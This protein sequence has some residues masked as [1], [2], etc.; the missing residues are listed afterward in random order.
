MPGAH[1]TATM[2]ATA[3]PA[4]AEVAGF[5]LPDM[6]YE[7]DAINKAKGTFPISDAAAEGTNGE[8]PGPPARLH[9]L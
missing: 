6:S 7:E 2:C 9:L 4:G 8:L 5:K 1:R 3:V